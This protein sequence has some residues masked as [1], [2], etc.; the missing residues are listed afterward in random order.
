MPIQERFQLAAEAG[1]DAMEVRGDDDLVGS[2]E[3]LRAL[4]DLS[5]RTLPIASMMAA[6]GWRPSLTSDEPEERRRALELFRR[7]IRAA[8]FLGADAV[9]VVPGVVN[10][11]V[12]YP[13]AWERGQEA[14]RD[15]ARTAEEFGVCLCVEN[16]WNKFL[17]S[18]LEMRRF[19]DEIGHPLVQVYFDVGNVLAFGYPEQWI[20]VLGARI[21]RVHV[22]DFKTAVGNITGFVQLLEGDVNWPAVM[23][24][25]RRVG[26]DGYLTAEVAPYR[27]LANKG[28]VDLARSI[29]AIQT[30]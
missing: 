30:V 7:T 18:P 10:E 4:A 23:A 29:D 25:L 28:I 16:V 8:R 9:L 15:L 24:A 27:H 11:T 21:K 19:V 2:E 20:D 22:K 26:Y 6:A 14:L 13:V 1:F 5:R 3:R 12:S 17:L